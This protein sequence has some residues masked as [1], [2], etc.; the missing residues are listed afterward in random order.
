MKFLGLE[1]WDVTD[2]IRDLVWGI[3]THLRGC[4]ESNRGLQGILQEN[5]FVKSNLKNFEK[6]QGMWCVRSAE[7]K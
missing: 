1:N 4:L 2:G 3:R 7:L 6:E 5:S